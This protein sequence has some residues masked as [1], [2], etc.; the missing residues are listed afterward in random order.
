MRRGKAGRWPRSRRNPELPRFEHRYRCSTPVIDCLL[1][2]YISGSGSRALGSGEVPDREH[3]LICSDEA[4]QPGLN[5][6]TPPDVRC[7][8][9]LGTESSSVCSLIVKVKIPDTKPDCPRPND[10][11]ARNVECV[12]HVSDGLLAS[13]HV[14]PQ[15]EGIKG[16]C[17]ALSRPRVDVLLD[18]TVAFLPLQAPNV[19]LMR[20]EA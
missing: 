17:P 14:S 9:C 15:D 19:H 8:G 11:A 18:V 1:L 3:S 7:C 12:R 6:S 4:Y 16:M 2:L 13:F 20:L 10:L 5:V